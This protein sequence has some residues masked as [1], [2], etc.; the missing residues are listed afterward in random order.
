MNTMNLISI[1]HEKPKPKFGK[2]ILGN[3][4]KPAL[5][6][7][8]RKFLLVD[9]S[10]DLRELVG[11]FLKSLGAEVDFA[12]NGAAGFKMALDSDFDIVIMDIQMPEMNG[13]EATKSLRKSGFKKPIIALT[14]MGLKNMEQSCLNAGCDFYISKPV[15][16]EILISTLRTALGKAKT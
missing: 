2:K 8:N 7:H 16:F 11:Y 10:E 13:L 5:E 9:D 6:F 3:S 1:G 4:S 14:A 12:D 15:N